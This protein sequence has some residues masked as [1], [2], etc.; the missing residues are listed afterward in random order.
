MSHTIR[1]CHNQLRSF[2]KANFIFSVTV[3]LSCNAEL[4]AIEDPSYLL[5]ILSKTRSTIPKLELN[6]VFMVLSSSII[7]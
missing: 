1:G 4:L 7:G 3:C 2:L 6:V 5:D